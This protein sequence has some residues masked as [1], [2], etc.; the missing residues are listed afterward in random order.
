MLVVRSVGSVRVGGSFSLEREGE[1]ERILSEKFYAS[2]RAS[3][4]ET[5]VKRRVERRAP[6]LNGEI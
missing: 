3:G 1:G 5:T 2:S 6:A 4:E